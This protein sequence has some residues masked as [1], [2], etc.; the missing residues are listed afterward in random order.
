MTLQTH[1]QAKGQ[2]AGLIKMPWVPGTEYSGAGCINKSEARVPNP[3][4]PTGLYLTPR[5]PQRGVFIW[6][7]RRCVFRFSLSRDG[8]FSAHQP[9]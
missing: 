3:H 6:V 8:G 7:V 2:G 1:G 5:S 9:E 4:S